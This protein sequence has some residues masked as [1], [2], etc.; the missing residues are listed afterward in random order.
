M[1]LLNTLRNIKLNILLVEDDAIIARME[2]QQLEQRGYNVI[3]VTSGEEAVK[4]ISEETFPVDLILMDIDLGSGINGTQAALSVMKMKDIPVI[5]LTSHTEPEIVEQTEKITSYG[6]VVKNTGIVVLDASI[7]M[8]FKL[9]YVNKKSKR[10]NDKLA[11]MIVS[12]R[13]HQDELQT[14]NEEL[15]EKQVELEALQLKYIKL[16]DMAPAGY[17]ILSDTGLILEVNLTGSELLGVVRGELLNQ[18]FTSFI[19]NED[20][21][22]FY[23]HRKKQFNTQL[24]ESC[25]VRMRKSNGSIYSVYM[26]TVSAHDENR[27]QICHVIMMKHDVQILD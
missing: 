11:S 5:F 24:Q 18:Q 10:I 23:L 2:K 20:Q 21:D 17:F 1:I 12:L 22:L 4:S 27:S 15:F 3:H 16:Y 8:A 9:F 26:K 6:Y 14:Q 19:I 25:E 13:L 7:K